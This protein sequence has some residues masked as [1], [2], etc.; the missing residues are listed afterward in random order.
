MLRSQIP[1]LG[2]LSFAFMGK[3]ACTLQPSMVGQLSECYKILPD[4]F[5]SPT[6]YPSFFLASLKIN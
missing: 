1:N 2:R 3:H 6:L 4:E 5:E